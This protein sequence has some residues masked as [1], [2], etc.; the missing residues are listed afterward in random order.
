MSLLTLKKSLLVAMTALALTACGGD[1]ASTETS[2]P[3]SAEQAATTDPVTAR[4]DLMQDWRAANEI[5][6]GMSDNPANF[7]AAVAKE[8]A[9]LLADG[10]TK[11]WEYFADANQKGKS[12]DAV[13]SDAAGF[14]AAADKFNAAAAALNTAAQSATQIGDLEAA[15]GQVGESCGGCH[16]VY[17]Q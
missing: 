16:K 17:K 9:Q 10:S 14:K 15:M 11:M 13:W 7:D 5:L 1:K 6:K 4:Q 3:A 2:A 8:Q 12:Q